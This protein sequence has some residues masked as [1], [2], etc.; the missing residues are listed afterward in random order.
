MKNTI[1]VLISSVS[2]ISYCVP[3][4]STLGP[5][6]FLV[7]VNDHNFVLNDYVPYEHVAKWIQCLDY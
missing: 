3:Q 7:C 5:V 1:R 4:E 6:L 2:N